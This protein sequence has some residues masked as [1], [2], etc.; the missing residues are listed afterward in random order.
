MT[1]STIRLP[2][3]R[4]ISYHLSGP[5]SNRIV[6]LSNSLC[7]P[8][9]SLDKVVP[10]L[11]S[12]DFTVLRYDQ[13]G[14]GTSSAPTDASSTTFETLADD[15]WQLLT[16][17]QIHKLHAWIGVSMGAATGFYFV[18]KHP[19]VVNKLVV[20]D[21]ISCSPAVA[22]IQDVFGPR[23][24]L[25]QKH[26]RMDEIV[27]QT[28]PRWF[29]LEWRDVNPAELDRMRAIMSETRVDGFAACC[30]ALRSSTFDIRP[31]A[32]RLGNCV[33]AAL[34]VVGELDANLPTSMEQLRQDAQD[35]FLGLHNAPC[36]EIIPSAGH[37]CYVDGYDRFCRIL[38]QFLPE[39]A[40][41]STK[42]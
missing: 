2:D 21:T 26:G 12:Q 37:I 35:G 9:K 39:S 6:L 36:L 3:R 17:L 20:C 7:A 24:Q 16:Y 23:I 10:F 38:E 30:N 32:K 1:S 33:D 15:A 25:A 14:H 11:S 5:L 40:G 29:S 13:P 4:D 8:Y 27:E 31:L 22:G 19:K 28:L 34:F 42:L 18:N 41:A